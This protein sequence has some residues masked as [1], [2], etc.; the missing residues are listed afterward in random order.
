MPKLPQTLFPVLSNDEPAR[1][2]QSRQLATDTEI[3]KR[4]RALLRFRLDTGVRKAEVT[5][6]KYEDVYLA[7]GREAGNA[8]SSTLPPL[9]TTCGCG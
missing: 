1:I 4:N 8:S 5:I 3:G 6:V 7:D 2:Y 9:P